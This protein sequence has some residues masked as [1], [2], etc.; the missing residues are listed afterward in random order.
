MVS[1][2]R[3]VPRLGVKGLN[4]SIPCKTEDKGNRFVPKNIRIK[5]SFVSIKML[6]CHW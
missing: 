3:T 6:I 1:S 4:I 5:N 2:P